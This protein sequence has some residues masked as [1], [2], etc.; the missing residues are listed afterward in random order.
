MK[1]S[2]LKDFLKLRRLKVSGR[3]CELVSRV[4]AA[5]END[6]KIVKTAEEVEGQLR[7]E[8][9][10]KLIV[11][12]YK[13]LCYN[14]IHLDFCFKIRSLNKFRKIVEKLPYSFSFY[15]KK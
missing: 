5:V 13:S 9:H 11:T 6:I 12:L 8:Y 7:N 1:V 15:P 14:V 10:S 3:K 4:F 2:E